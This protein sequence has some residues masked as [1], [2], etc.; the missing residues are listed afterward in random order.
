MIVAPVLGAAQ[1][2]PVLPLDKTQEWQC[3]V[4][5]DYFDIDYFMQPE[6]IGPPTAQ[7]H[8]LSITCSRSQLPEWILPFHSLHEFPGDAAVPW[9]FVNGEGRE[10]DDEAS[11][12]GAELITVVRTGSGGAVDGS[13][14]PVPNLNWSEDWNCEVD[15]EFFPAWFGAKKSAQPDQVKLTCSRWKWTLTDLDMNIVILPP[16]TSSLNFTGL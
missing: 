14:W 16:G 3:E 10:A 12:V 13:S 8:R 15:F 5:I 1:S 7:P 6:I 4:D 2:W 9:H 11:T